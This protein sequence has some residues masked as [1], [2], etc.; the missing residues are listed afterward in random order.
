MRRLLRVLAALLLLGLA[1]P[2]A[3]QAVLAA[4]ASGSEPSLESQLLGLT[5]S[6]RAKAGVPAL[7][8]SAALVAVAQAWSAHQAATGALAHNPDLAGAVSGWSALAENVASA[9]TVAQAE[10]M[11]LASPDHRANIVNSRYDRVGIGVTR[12]ADGTLW[13]TVDFEQ[14]SG[15]TPPAASSPPAAKPKPPAKAARPVAPATA[16]RPSKVASSQA[17]ASA[18]ARLAAERAAVA[19][20]ANR[21]LVRGAT[22]TGVGSVS[23]AVRGGD[24]RMVETELV[25]PAG[26]FR[27]LAALGPLTAPVGPTS[28]AGLVVLAAVATLAVVGAVS[29]QLLLRDSYR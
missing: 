28:P 24:A 6:V 1:V 26:G 18:A 23:A 20:R 7:R 10:S 27:T 3:A 16:P 25:S 11:F 21:S 29:T 22:P 9:P 5:N 15:Y 19:A 17:P 8:S 2:V 4:S 12:A 13:V 14:T